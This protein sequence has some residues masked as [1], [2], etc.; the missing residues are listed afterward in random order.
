MN[1]KIARALV[2]AAYEQG[3][4]DACDD[5]MEQQANP[6]Y[7]IGRGKHAGVDSLLVTLDPYDL[8]G[9]RAQ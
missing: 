2:N 6:K 3:W 4:R 9:L 8:L 1:R 7:P 5:Q